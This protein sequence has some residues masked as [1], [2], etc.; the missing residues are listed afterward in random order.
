MSQHPRSALDRARLKTYAHL[1]PL[2]FLS[3]VVAYVDRVNVAF[4]KLTMSQDLPAFNN[5]VIGW[6]GGVFFAG[7]FLL[8]IPGSVIV[9]RWSARRWISRIMISWGI[10]ASLTALVKT[11]VHFYVVRFVLGL[12]EA[13]FFPGVIVILSRWFPRRDRARAHPRVKMATPR[14]PSLGA[15]R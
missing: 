7:Y 2:L 3:Y 10:I 13:G 15:P 4:A 11:P 1:L 14:A 6:G 9:E 12:A 8:E 5:S